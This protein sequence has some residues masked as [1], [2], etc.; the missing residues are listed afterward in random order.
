MPLHET[1]YIPLSG[2]RGSVNTR[3]MSFTRWSASVV[4]LG[5]LAAWAIR[6]SSPWYQV[7]KAIARCM[8]SSSVTNFRIGPSSNG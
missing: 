7:T 8:H 6:D 2:Y 4:S 3:T 1:L 5:V